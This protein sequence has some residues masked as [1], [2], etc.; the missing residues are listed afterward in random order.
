MGE[1]DKLSISEKTFRW[2]YKNGS[3]AKPKR[4]E[5]DRDR[6]LFKINIRDQA[7]QW[8]TIKTELD[9]QT[10]AAFAKSLLDR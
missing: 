2:K 8:N 10:H 9:I 3:A 1:S 7:G 4:K 6:Q 5:K